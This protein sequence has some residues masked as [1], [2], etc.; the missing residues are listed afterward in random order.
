M[1]ILKYSLS[2]IGLLFTLSAF[3]KT[4]SH[5]V[6]EDETAWFISNVY[7]GSGQ[8]FPKLLK[9]NSLTRAEDIREGMTI[10]IEDPKFDKSQV[11]FHARYQRL[12][13]DRQKALGL[14]KGDKLPVS[15]V[16]I[17]TEK[18]MGRDKTKLPFSDL[19]PEGKSASELAHEE[20]LKG[21]RISQEQGQ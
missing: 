14:T 21:S 19:R 17:P 12:W 9:T 8:Q 7:Y 11:E 6:L 20:L 13:S 10:Q 15:K 2:A 3:S 4:V 18:I 5:H 1:R 16:V